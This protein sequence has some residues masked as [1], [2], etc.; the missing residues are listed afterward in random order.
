MDVW[1]REAIDLVGPGFIKFNADGTGDFASSPSTV[2]SIAGAPSAQARRELTSPGRATTTVTAHRAAG[3]PSSRPMARFG[4]TSS[5]T[6]AMTPASGRSGKRVRL[7]GGLDGTHRQG[8]PPTV[9]PVGRR[10]VSQQAG[11]VALP[12]GHSAVSLLDDTLGRRSFAPARRTPCQARHRQGSPR[13][14]ASSR[15]RV[16]DPRVV[17]SVRPSPRRRHDLRPV[18]SRR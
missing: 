3:G 9:G 6:L 2:T 1:D 8:L 5:S 18:R 10:P 13:V 4:A 7:T 17:V 12:F 14:N 11:R 15:M 16:A